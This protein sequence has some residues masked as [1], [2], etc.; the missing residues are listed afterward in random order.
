MLELKYIF[1]LSI[2]I[3]LPVFW[4]GSAHSQFAQGP[5]IYDV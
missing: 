2:V 4:F 1:H 3:N 5:D